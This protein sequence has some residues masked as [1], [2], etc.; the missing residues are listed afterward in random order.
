MSSSSIMESALVKFTC[1]SGIFLRI[2]SLINIDHGICSCENGFVVKYTVV[3]REV[4]I[5]EGYE[6]FD[7]LLMLEGKLVTW[8][9]IVCIT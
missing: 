2:V 1:T 6:A 9:R 8:R 5:R 3:A 4:G 7:V